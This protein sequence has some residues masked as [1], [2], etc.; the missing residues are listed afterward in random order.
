M[1]LAGLYRGGSLGIKARIFLFSPLFSVLFS[2]FFF[3]FLSVSRE[4]VR[5]DCRVQPRDSREC[6]DVSRKEAFYAFESVV[7]VKAA[8]TG[9]G[10]TRARTTTADKGVMT[11]MDGIDGHFSRA[12]YARCSSPPRGAGNNRPE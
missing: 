3:F 2:S 8:L 9:G 7:V 12:R 1:Q 11:L 10:C 4:D 5:G 6:L